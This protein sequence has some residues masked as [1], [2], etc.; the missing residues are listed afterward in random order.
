MW[1]QRQPHSSFLTVEQTLAKIRPSQ[2]NSPPWCLLGTAGDVP[3]PESGARLCFQL[4]CEPSQWSWANVLT[5]STG[6]SIKR[7]FLR[8]LLAL[9]PYLEG[10]RWLLPGEPLALLWEKASRRLFWRSYSDN[11]LPRA[12]WKR[13]DAQNKS[14]SHTGPSEAATREAVCPKGTLLIDGGQILRC[15]CVRGWIPGSRRACQSDQRRQGALDKDWTLST[16]PRHSH[17]QCWQPLDQAQL[18]HC[19]DTFQG[20]SSRGLAANTHPLRRARP[21]CLALAILSTLSN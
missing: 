8:S 16:S 17:R 13:E 1:V 7:Q 12:S 11:V 10:H 19:W 21:P 4:R 20:S 14:N 6:L 15:S 3:N 18:C 9:P 2:R 5:H